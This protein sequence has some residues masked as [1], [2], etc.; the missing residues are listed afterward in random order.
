VGQLKKSRRSADRFKRPVIGCLGLAFKADVDD[1]RESPSV[2]IVR[3]LLKENIGEI[4]I[5]EPNLSR[6]DEFELLPHE[7]VIARSDIV[8]LLV[9]H[10]E[11][12]NLKAADMKE[13]IL[14]DTR[15]VIT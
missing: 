7:Q 2:G 3:Q 13:K 9:N 14:I 15:G 10:K 1:L 4:I 11:F 8:L 5:S 6:H 12:R